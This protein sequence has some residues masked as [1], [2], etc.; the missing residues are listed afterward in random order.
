MGRERLVAGLW[1]EWR[2]RS[3]RSSGAESP[4]AGT[5]WIRRLRPGE[6]GCLLRACL[7][8]GVPAPK[9][10]CTWRGVVK[11]RLPS[12]NGLFR[13]FQIPL[14]GAFYVKSNH[15]SLIAVTAT[16][17]QKED[18][19]LSGG[20]GGCRGDL[21]GWT[22][23]ARGAPLLLI[24]AGLQAGVTLAS[25]RLGGNPDVWRCEVG[26]GPPP[27]IPRLPGC[28]REEEGCG[29]RGEAG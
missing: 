29:Y 2:P 12:V 6:Q 3:G 5:R 4:G 13:W 25:S 26:M 9:V 1:C 14:E 7:G 23:G 22:A 8:P 10:L 24:P 11:S 15:F 21:G 28:W 19:T 17:S 18:L 20:G 16:T 27:A